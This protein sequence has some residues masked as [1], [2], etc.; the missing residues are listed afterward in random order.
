MAP[1]AFYCAILKKIHQI[2]LFFKQIKFILMCFGHLKI[3]LSVVRCLR[4]YDVLQNS[5]IFED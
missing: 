2:F 1:D 5:R 3:Y 4:V